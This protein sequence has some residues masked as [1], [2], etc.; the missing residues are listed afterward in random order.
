MYT[1]AIITRQT[2]SEF[3]ASK[4]KKYYSKPV[5]RLSMG[6]G[7]NKEF[8][9]QDNEEDIQKSCLVLDFFM[10]RKNGHQYLKKY[11]ILQPNEV[12]DGAGAG[13]GAGGGA[14]AGAGA[15]A[16]G[17]AGAGAGEE[18]FSEEE[19]N[20]EKEEKGEYI[21]EIHALSS[22]NP[23][24]KYKNKKCFASEEGDQK[25]KFVDMWLKLAQDIAIRSGCDVLVLDDGA[26]IRLH[27]EHGQILID[28]GKP[29][30]G[31][32]S[33]RTLLKDGIT[34]YEKYGFKFIKDEGY[35]KVKEIHLQEIEPLLNQEYKEVL[36]KLK[37]EMNEDT[38]VKDVYKQLFEINQ[39]NKQIFNDT[40]LHNFVEFIF[41]K[42]EKFGKS[43]NLYLD[44]KLTKKDEIVVKVHSLVDFD[45]E[46]KIYMLLSEKQ[47]IMNYNKGKVEK[48]YIENVNDVIYAS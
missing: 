40:K 13:A 26:S 22:F 5:I 38:K 18:E 44:L 36:E 4:V 14:G 10:M 6:A 11:S 21:C 2:N 45:Q 7:M 35:K 16:G 24:E 3:F 1:S 46:N 20:D 48:Q 28:N 33:M 41:T 17:G 37:I 43:S 39:E 19:M 31:D 9:K 30:L 32:I 42:S 12:F 27:D 15:G 23:L 47:N 29:V 8:Q 34:F 25:I